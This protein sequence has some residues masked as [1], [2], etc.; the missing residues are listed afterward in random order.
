MRVLVVMDP[1]ETVNLKKD[2]TMAMLWAASRRGHELGYALQQD[3]YID[4]GKAYGLIAPLKVFEDYNH[5]YELG[6]KKKNQS[7]LMML[8]SCVKTRL[9]T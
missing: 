4:Q 6:E 1:I 2:S 9:L 5:Y 8:S 3:L 7:R